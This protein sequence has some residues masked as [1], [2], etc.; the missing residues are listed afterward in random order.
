MVFS[1]FLGNYKLQIFCN[2]YCNEIFFCVIFL[3]ERSKDSKGEMMIQTENIFERYGQ[4]VY[5][6]LLVLCKDAD[7]AEELTQE[8]FYQAIKNAHR[9]DGTCKMSTWLCQIGKHMWLRELRRR[10]KLSDAELN[11]D[12]VSWEQGPEEQYQNKA[13]VL[14]TMK[15]LHRLPEHEKEVVLLRATESLSFKEIGEIMGKSESWARVTFF[16]AKQKLKEM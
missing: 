1:A 12:M 5:R 8:T 2:F 14:E 16:R 11:E 3:C 15:K 13:E 10:K 6:Y 4:M 9:F 7:L